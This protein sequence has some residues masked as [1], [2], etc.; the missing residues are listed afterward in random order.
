[1]YINQCMAAHLLRTFDAPG[2]P[3]TAEKRRAVGDAFEALHGTHGATRPRRRSPP[4]RAPRQR[5][6]PPGPD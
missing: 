6:P 2:D 4:H 3:G 5:P 1:M